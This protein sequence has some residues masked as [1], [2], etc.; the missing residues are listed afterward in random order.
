MKTFSAED[1]LCNTVEGNMKGIGVAKGVR[2]GSVGNPELQ[3]MPK[4]K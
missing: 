2:E 4:E 1:F 3:L